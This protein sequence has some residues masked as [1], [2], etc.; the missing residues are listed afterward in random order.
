MYTHTISELHNK[1]VESGFVV[2]KIIEPDSRKRYKL[3]PWYGLWN[4]TPKFL[5][6]FPQTIIFKCKK[7]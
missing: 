5:K 1:L 3:D 7:I 2:E 6:M 4:Y